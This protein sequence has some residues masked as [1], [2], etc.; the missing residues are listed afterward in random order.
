MYTNHLPQELIFDP[1]MK[2]K[3]S[4]PIDDIIISDSKSNLEPHYVHQSGSK[5]D[6]IMVSD[7]KEA[8]QEVDFE[9]NDKQDIAFNA[10]LD[11]E[12]RFMMWGYIYN[13]RN[14]LPFKK[15]E[16]F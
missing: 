15:G 16:P 12:Q 3:A 5:V 10:L 9:T 1:K 11:E 13:L 14:A 6:P 2:R 8:N 7:F 4:E